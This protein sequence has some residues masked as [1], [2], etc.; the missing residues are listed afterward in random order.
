MNSEYFFEK[1]LYFIRNTFI[2]YF[3]PRYWPALVINSFYFTY[4]PYKLITNNVKT[5]YDVDKIIEVHRNRLYFIK[6][7]QSSM[8]VWPKK[9][10]IFTKPP[11]AYSHINLMLNNIVQVRYFN[12]N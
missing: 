6:Y 9:I 1:I 4:L 8:I 12:K 2:N 3:Y 11:H 7:L 10:K 5:F